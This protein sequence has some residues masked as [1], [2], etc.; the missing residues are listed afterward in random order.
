MHLT[1]ST[2]IIRGTHSLRE[3]TN[4]GLALFAFKVFN[5]DLMWSVCQY[6]LC[7]RFVISDYSEKENPR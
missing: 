4:A 3:L 5:I 7:R 6:D 1:V 2:M